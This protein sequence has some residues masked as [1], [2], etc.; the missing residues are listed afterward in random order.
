M[1]LRKCGFNAKWT[2]NEIKTLLRRSLAKQ[3]RERKGTG[4]NGD[5]YFTTFTDDQA[6]RAMDLF[7]TTAPASNSHWD[8]TF[9]RKANKRSAKA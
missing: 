5:F 3:Q 6:A 7:P 4:T 8:Y 2:D 1:A 9:I